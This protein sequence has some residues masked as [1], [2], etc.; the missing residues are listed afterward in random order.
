MS[1]LECPICFEPYD[2]GLR[3][4]MIVPCG[5]MHGLCTSCVAMLKMDDSAEF[6]CPQCRETIENTARINQNRGLM[7]A[8]QALEKKEA[9]A[10]EAGGNAIASAPYLTMSGGPD[11]AWHRTCRHMPHGRRVVNKLPVGGVGD[12]G[13]A[14]CIFGGKGF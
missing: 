5:G 12:R 4:P 1:E 2:T 9:V 6:K 7:A 3:A 11:G 13:L 8:L 10:V 14:G